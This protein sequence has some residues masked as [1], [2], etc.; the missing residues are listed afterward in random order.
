[1]RAAIHVH[2]SYSTGDE[3]LREIAEQARANGLAVLILTDD[4][5]LEVSY[6]LPPWSR[7][8]RVTQSQEALFTGNRLETYLDEI[9]HLDASFEDLVIID[10][11]ESAPYYTWDV[12][13][14]QRRWTV[15][16]WNRHLLAIG[17]DSAD[18]YRGLPVLGGDGMWLP[19]DGSAIL[20]MLWPV[21]GLFYAL[22]LGRRM[23]GVFLRLLVSGV[24]L[25]FLLDGSLGDF[26]V[27]RFDANVDAGLQ[28]YQA[29]IDA[30]AAAEG[31]TFWAHP[32][33]ASTIPPHSIAGMVEVYSQTPAHAGDLLATQG[34]TGFAA[35]YADHTTATEPGREWD[36]TLIEY[37]QGRRARPSWGTGEIDYH[38]QERR[39]EIHD[40][41]TVLFVE[42]RSRPGV[43]EALTHGRAYAVRGGDDAL[44]LQRFVVATVVGEAISGQQVSTAGKPWTV[45]AVI[46]KAD[47]SAEV[48][49]L[50]LVRGTAQGQVEVVAAISGATPLH[51]EHIETHLAPDEQCYF[52]LLA[53][54]RTSM[55]TSN[56]I[57]LRGAD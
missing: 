36:Q 56:P 1:M 9:R 11:V 44:Q 5:L 13:W 31:L 30:V 57:F 55:L 23:H 25:L 3:S 39:A 18:A 33:A 48:V 45:S 47:G 32:E 41:Q 27:A 21:L 35:L 6:G 26:R 53:T 34:Y 38:R 54:S 4:D 40:I 52:R 37:L 28:P 17:L 49:D 19:Q 43:L 8:L 7:L 20:R 2:S 24:C 16:G 15:R 51:I 42:E 10:G 46:D 12:D 50:R 29:W 14:A 22:W